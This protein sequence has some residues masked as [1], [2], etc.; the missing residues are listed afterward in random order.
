MFDVTANMKIHG[1]H[2][3][4]LINNKLYIKSNE[5]ISIYY[6]LMCNVLIKPL[7]QKQN[8]K[9]E[10]LITFSNKHP[11]CETL[12]SRVLFYM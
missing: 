7:K 2:I 5:E 11:Y 9:F 3:S 8:N 10:G 6:S 12:P 1:T 4:E